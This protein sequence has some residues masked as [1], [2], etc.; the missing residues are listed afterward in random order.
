MFGPCVLYLVENTKAEEQFP[1]F[2]F[3]FA[4]FLGISVVLLIVLHTEKGSLPLATKYALYSVALCSNPSS[5][6]QIRCNR[7]AIYIY[8][9]IWLYL[10]L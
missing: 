2:T 8:I 5:V 10:K 4:L 7:N 6:E 3:S 1:F 9:Y